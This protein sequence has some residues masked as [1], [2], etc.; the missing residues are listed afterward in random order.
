MR[1]EIEAP[2]V[3]ID[4]GIWAVALSEEEAALAHSTFDNSLDNARTVTCVPTR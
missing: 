1:A 4:Q 3:L 2:H